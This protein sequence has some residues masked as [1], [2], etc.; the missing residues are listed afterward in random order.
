MT[1]ELAERKADL[2]GRQTD[3]LRERQRDACDALREVR[4]VQYQ[5]LLQRQRDERAALKVG[6]TLEALGIGRDQ[7]D[8]GVAKPMPARAA[9]ENQT[10]GAA[11]VELK[12]DTPHIEAARADVRPEERQRDDSIATV[13]QS[14]GQAVRSDDGNSIDLSDVHV[15]HQESKAPA[16]GVSDLAAAGIGSAASYL[17]DQLGEFFAPTPPEVREAQ[18]KAQ[19]KAD[20]NREAER[21]APEDKA[22]AYERIIESAVRAVEE[23]RAQ[24][25]E[26]W[27]KERDKGKGFERDQ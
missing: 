7:Q 23:E 15:S 10:I 13:A 18:A 24:Q 16:R 21:P 6:V 3:D 12:H 1:K 2:K 22:A 5:D 26:A 20:A 25:G 27:W 4:D 9:N 19:A 14:I 17:A 8:D 11:P